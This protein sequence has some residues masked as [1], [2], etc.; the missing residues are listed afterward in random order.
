MGT[1][2][3]TDIYPTLKLLDP[4]FISFCGILI[5]VRGP[6]LGFVLCLGTPLSTARLGLAH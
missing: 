6:Y 2:M 5:S 4:L 1:G 3:G